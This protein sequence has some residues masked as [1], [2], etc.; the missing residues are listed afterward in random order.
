MHWTLESL[1]D[2]VRVTS[3]KKPKPHRIYINPHDLISFNYTASS[4]DQH[5]IWKAGDLAHLCCVS[6][7]S[8]RSL[9]VRSSFK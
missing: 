7:E 9:S 6:E 8:D 5:H 3:N 2:S 4:K 1:G